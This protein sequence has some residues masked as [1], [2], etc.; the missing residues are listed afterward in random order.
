[1]YDMTIVKNEQLAGK[2]Y[3]HNETISGNAVE[4]AEDEIAVAW[5]GSLTT[6]TDND[7]G[8]IT[9]E[10]AGHLITTGAIVDLYWENTDGTLGTRYSVTV[11]TVSG[12]SV[13]FG[14]PGG[15]GAGD[16]LPAQD[17]DIQVALV[18]EYDATIDGDNAAALVGTADIASSI[19]RFMSTGGTVVELA[20]I[21]PAG[22]IYDWLGI[23]TN[24]LAGVTVDAIHMSHNDTSQV[25]NV[26]AAA[27]MDN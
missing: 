9:M 18:E 6:R 14:A 22:R 12:T 3:I 5:A 26:R 20:L 4:G 17:T 11:G 10:D 23:G 7:T 27:L 25:R 16:N 15:T 21:I 19:I 24:P 1:M 8:T 13:P 2:L